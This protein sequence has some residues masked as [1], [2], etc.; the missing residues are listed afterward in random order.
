MKK[1]IFLMLSSAFTLSACSTYSLE[2]L[3][4]AVP[5]GSSFQNSLASLYMNFA[6]AE[7]KDYDWQDSW[8]FADK[9]LLAVYGKD[10]MPEDPSNWNI[11]EDKLPELEQ[12]RKDL[13]AVLT[14]E[15]KEAR[16]EMA[17]L[18][19]FNFDC[20]VEQQEENWQA[21]DIEF[22]RDGFFKSLEMLKIYRSSRPVFLDKK[23]TKDLFKKSPKEEILKNE[24]AIVK[25][26]SPI[27]NS[28][29]VFFETGKPLLTKAGNSVVED[30]RKAVSSEESYEIIIDGNIDKSDSEKYKLM[31]ERAELVKRLLIDGGIKS[32]SILFGDNKKHSKVNLK[33]EI[34]VND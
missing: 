6:A 2:E 5:K 13:V 31:V 3:R 22:C 29:V 28:F 23:R 27:V 9:G 1:L 16:P 25:P 30:I 11:A 17:A 10:V 33:I 14:S 12:A 4:H 8:Y 18:A 20:W 19:Q 24:H 34:F 26:H 21:E 32:S 15:I 7:E